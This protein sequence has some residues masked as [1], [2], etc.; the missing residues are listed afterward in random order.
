MG[1]N[2]WGHG[3]GCLNVAVCCECEAVLALGSLFCSCCHRLADR[4]SWSWALVGE[5]L[6]RWD[7]YTGL[8]ERVFA[9][10]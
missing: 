10:S 3:F 2:F 1:E 8:V 7:F 5:I 4:R 6:I 9:S